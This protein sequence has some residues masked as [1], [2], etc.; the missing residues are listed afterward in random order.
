M[1]RRVT[2]DG[3]VD[4]VVESVTIAFAPIIY[5]LIC[6]SLTGRDGET[7]RVRG[8]EIVVLVAPNCWVD[9]EQLQGIVERAVRSW[10]TILFAAVAGV[11][12]TTPRPPLIFI[13]AVLGVLHLSRSRV[14]VPEVRIE[15]VG[16]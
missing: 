16:R 15:E 9:R 4:T 7:W 6:L 10:P 13:L 2:A 14:P 11:A 1:T 3:A 8:G 12:I 5:W